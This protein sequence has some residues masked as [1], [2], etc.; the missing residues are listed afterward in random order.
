MWA[1][2]DWITMFYD[3]IDAWNRGEIQGEGTWPQ[4]RSASL[5]RYDDLDRTFGL[6]RGAADDARAR[7]AQEAAAGRRGADGVVGSG[8]TPP[9]SEPSVS[10]PPVSEPEESD[11]TPTPCGQEDAVVDDLR[12]VIETTRPYRIPRPDLLEPWRDW[13]EATGCPGE[14]TRAKWEEW[15]A[16]YRANG[17]H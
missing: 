9:V 15:Y 1:N 10:E 16:A 7:F 2:P 5:Y 6:S 4:I 17:G 13:L 8:A 3:F 12:E 14:E 11:C